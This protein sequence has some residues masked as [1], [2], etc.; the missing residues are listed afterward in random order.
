MI[1][2]FHVRCYDPSVEDL[3]S[4]LRKEAA[5]PGGITPE[6]RY[7]LDRVNDWMV[8]FSDIP[9]IKVSV[10]RCGSACREG[11]RGVEV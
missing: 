6:G 8:A 1:T 10:E 3:F 5:S 9:T 11:W 7:V 2:R 4:A